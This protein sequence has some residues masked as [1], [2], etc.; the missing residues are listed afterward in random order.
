MKKS[1]AFLGL[2]LLSCSSFKYTS[3]SFFDPKPYD[4]QM[5]TDVK[6]LIYLC[7]KRAV[8]KERD[9]PDY[10]SS[11]IRPIFISKTHTILKTVDSLLQ[12]NSMQ[13]L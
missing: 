6:T 7:L 1:I 8:V 10:A 13:V 2:A 4:Y 12:R 11:P 5:N 9:I 3:K